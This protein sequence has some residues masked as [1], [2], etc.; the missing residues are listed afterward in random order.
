M[1]QPHYLVRQAKLGDVMYFYNAVCSI[2]NKELDVLE[3]NAIFR[4]KLKN[5]DSFLMVLEENNTIAGC[6]VAQLRRQLSVEHSFIEIQELYIT[7]KYRKR[8]A[9]DFL[10]QAI[11]QYFKD[12]N[13]HQFQVACFINSTLSQN[14]YTKKG[15]KIAKKK[16][17]K[18]I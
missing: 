5:K 18:E 7:P 4:E 3:F 9:A 1:D 10:Y 14:F 17:E 2:L 12:K 11:E 6:I 16:Y 13:H 15:F 8:K